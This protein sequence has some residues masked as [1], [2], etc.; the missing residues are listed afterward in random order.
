MAS[1]TLTTIGSY[2]DWLS[3]NPSFIHTIVPILLPALAVPELAA[4]ASLALKDIAQECRE[5]LRP[6]ND[7]ILNHCMVSSKFERWMNLA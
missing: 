4:P 5:S 6:Y 1:T 2:A 3:F 7:D